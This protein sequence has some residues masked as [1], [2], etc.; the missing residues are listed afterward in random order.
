[1][2]FHLV[3]GTVPRSAILLT[4]VTAPAEYRFQSELKILEVLYNLLFTNSSFFK[5]LL[6]D[7]S[8]GTATG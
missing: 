4:L 2:Y 1:M 5:N 6:I 3:G 8:P 7:D